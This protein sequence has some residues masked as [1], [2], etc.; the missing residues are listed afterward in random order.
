MAF[1][2]VTDYNEA[3]FGNFFLL[4]ND[5]DFADVIFLY[6]SRD[7]ELVGPTHYIKSEDYSGYVQCLGKGCPACKKGIRVQ[8]K[9]FIPLYNIETGEIQFWD[10]S[11]RFESQLEQ[12]V[13]KYFPNPSECVFRITRHGAA[14]DINTTYQIQAIGK[15]TIKSYAQILAENNA[16]SPDYFDMVC[17]EFSA[18]ELQNMLNENSSSSSTS[19]SADGL[20]NYQVRPRTNSSTSSDNLPSYTAPTVADTPEDDAEIEELDDNVTF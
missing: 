17:K 1:Q 16:K 8:T 2:K 4:R 5:G 15:N 3:R 7:D 13:F 20:P 9:L 10:R 14:G 18:S 19:Y 6:R 11:M 12:S